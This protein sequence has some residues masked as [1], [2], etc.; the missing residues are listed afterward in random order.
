MGRPKARIIIRPDMVGVYATTKYPLADVSTKQ[1][2]ATTTG[3]TQRFPYAPSVSL[4]GSWP[5]YLSKA[6]LSNSTPPLIDATLGTVYAMDRIC[7]EMIRLR[8][9]I[10][11]KSRLCILGGGGFV[12]NTGTK[13]P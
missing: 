7:T 1:L 10:T 9:K 3:T 11:G 2:A 6:G 5:S 4:S 8:N 13:V 12:G